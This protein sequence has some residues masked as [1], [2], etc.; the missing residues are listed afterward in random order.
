M[1]GQLAAEASPIVERMIS[2]D[3]DDPVAKGP[4]W[5]LAHGSGSDSNRKKTSCV[6]V[7]ASTGGQ[8][9]ADGKRD[10]GLAL[11]ITGLEH[12]AVAPMEG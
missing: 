10:N 2:R 5:K 8:Y 9:P 6:M 12:R 11:T 1:A 3:L 7:S 4:P